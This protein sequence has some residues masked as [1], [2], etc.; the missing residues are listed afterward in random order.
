MTS[1][2]RP[3]TSQHDMRCMEIW[4]GNRAIDSAIS[5]VG[6]DAYIYSMP[7]AGDERGG[8]VHY[9]SMCMA[10]CVARF[11]VADVSGH[12]ASVD[13][14]ARTLRG[15]MRK[16]INTP[17]QSRFVQALNDE[18]T[19][20]SEAGIFATALL[21]SYFAPERQLIVS[22]AGHPRPLWY[23]AQ[24]NSWAVL[25][26]SSDGLLQEHA[27]DLPL[28]VI[29]PTDYHQFAVQLHPGD[30]VL[31]YTDALTEARSPDGSL[32]GEAGLFDIVRLLDPSEPTAFLQ[33]V[34]DALHSHRGGAEPDDDETLMLLA[35]TGAEPRKPSLGERLGAISRMMGLTPMT[36]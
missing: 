6:V 35:S 18:F 2:T 36:S 3:A 34:R 11:A 25:T 8:D 12:G 4:G 16:H 24:S 33:S 32:L 1:T 31:I 9:V 21:T 15:L 19:Q 29:E 30:R 26:E 13:A 20:Q 17:D 27:A 14:F 28:G 23:R 7:H 5:T 10:G 22:N